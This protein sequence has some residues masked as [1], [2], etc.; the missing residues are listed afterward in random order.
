MPP[1][2]VDWVLV[3]LREGATPPAATTVIARRAG[4]LKSNGDIV[5]LDGTSPLSFTDL[6]FSQD[7]YPLVRHRNHLAAMAADPAQSTGPGTYACDMSQPGSIFGSGW[8]LLPG[9]NL[10]MVAA[11]GFCDKHVNNSDLQDN[12]AGWLPGFGFSGMYTF[13]DFNLDGEV[14]NTDFNIYW[15]INFGIS[16]DIP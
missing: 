14:N 4:L 1:G 11:N 7:L 3:E 13:A 6:T 16:D 9:G 10:G 15:L 5:D 8:K 2:V 12:T